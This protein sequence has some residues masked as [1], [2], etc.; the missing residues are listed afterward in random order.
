MSRIVVANIFNP[1][2]VRNVNNDPGNYSVSIILFK[3]TYS[4]S[5]YKPMQNTPIITL[6][7]SIRET[8]LSIYLF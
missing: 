8:Q 5:V 2:V 6:V 7:E 1:G 4:P 3:N